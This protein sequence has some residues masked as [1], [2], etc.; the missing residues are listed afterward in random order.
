MTKLIN[1]KK[2]REKGYNDH[3]AK[4]YSFYLT[5]RPI[6][7]PKSLLLRSPIKKTLTFHG[8]KP[9]NISKQLELLHRINLITSHNQI[10]LGIHA[11]HKI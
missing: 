8:D 10:N 3:V 9:K 1:D 5:T 2:Q 6:I 7:V 4:L 11:K